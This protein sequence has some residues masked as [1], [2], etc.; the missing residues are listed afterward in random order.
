MEDKA[1]MLKD[2]LTACLAAL[3]QFINKR[4]N[5]YLSQ[6][7]WS[8]DTGD[9]QGLAWDSKMVART[10]DDRRKVKRYSAHLLQLINRHVY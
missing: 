5:E 7:K 2:D 6:L 4:Q 10:E 8:M 1:E 3:E 9:S